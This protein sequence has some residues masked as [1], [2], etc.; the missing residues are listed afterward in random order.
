MPHSTDQSEAGCVLSL[1]QLAIHFVFIEFVW[2]CL[3]ANKNRMLCIA[4]F[5]AQQTGTVYCSIQHRIIQ[6]IYVQC[7]ITRNHAKKSCCVAVIVIVSFIELLCYYC[8]SS[9]SATIRSARKVF[10]QQF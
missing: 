8:V 1:S 7:Q 4:V 2:W 6:N 9:S 3:A 10:E 5:E